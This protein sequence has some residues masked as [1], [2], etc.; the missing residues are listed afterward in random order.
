MELDSGDFVSGR[1][2]RYSVMTSEDSWGVIEFC[3]FLFVI[4]WYDDNEIMSDLF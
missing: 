3:V 2:G 1:G 4:G